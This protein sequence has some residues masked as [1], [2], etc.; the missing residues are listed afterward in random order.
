M[1]IPHSTRIASL[2]LA[3][4]F[5][6]GCSAP[7]P[8]IE[9]TR[10]H[11]NDGDLRTALQ[12]AETA[13]ENDPEDAEAHYYLG[14]VYHEMAMDENAIS[15]REEYYRNMRAS[16]DSALS[17]LEDQRRRSLTSDI[18]YLIKSS[19]SNEHNLGY[20]KLKEAENIGSDEADLALAYLHNAIII[21]PDSIS[22]Y[23][24]ASDAYL[25]L[26]DAGQAFE[27]L[28]RAVDRMPDFHQ[29]LIERHAYLAVHAGRYEQA[30]TS[31]HKLQDRGYEDLNLSHGLVNTLKQAGEHYKAVEILED[32]IRQN[33]DNPDYTLTYA[34][35]FYGISVQ[36]FE[37][38]IELYRSNPLDDET[39]SA[40]NNAL[41]YAE[42]AENK[43]LEAEEL[44][45]SSEDII[46]ARAI[47]YQNLTAKLSDIRT[48]VGSDEYLE[49]LNHL[50]D[51]YAHSAIEL[52]EE[53]VEQT[54]D[55]AYYW[56]SLFQ[57]YSFT[58]QTEKA[59]HARE[60]FE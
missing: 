18:E 20:T 15:Q 4:G 23:E 42:Q 3:F 35:Q 31:Y 26:D 56:E 41:S 1:V 32:I 37:Q 46:S 60:Q 12:A 7:N 51:Q 28:D 19:W 8:Y 40:F 48:G 9:N 22:S 5:L 2:V 17:L 10:E 27:M 44:A 16:F 30:L 6:F 29:P 11:I 54:D 58:D 57:L 36:R 43:F 50:V 25:K 14:V 52:F 24:L 53:I 45:P 49:E 47:F 34:K 55:P 38:W 13:I 59:D 39:R 21:E 33:P